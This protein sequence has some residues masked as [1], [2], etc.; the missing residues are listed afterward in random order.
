MR[1]FR[2]K[3][4]KH[5]QAWWIWVDNNEVHVKHGIVGGKL[6]HTYD[7]M[8]GIKEGTRAYVSPKANALAEMDR[9]IKKKVDAGYYEVDD[10][11][12]AIGSTANGFDFTELP[13][14][15]C[16][17]KPR[18]QP[19]EG[20]REHD[21][22]L[23]VLDRGD[24][25][26]TVKRDGFMHPILVTPE[27][28]VRIYTRR[29]DE[30]TSKYPHLA[31]DIIAAKVP[32]RSVLLC[33][34]FIRPTKTN[35]EDRLKMQAVSNSLPK[36]A[37]KLQELPENRVRA[38]ILLVPFWNGK[39]NADLRFF[40]LLQLAY[41]INTKKAKHFE[42]IDILPETLEDARR[43]V[44]DN[45]WEGL[46]IYDGEAEP[47]AK[48]FNF[49]GKPERPDCWKDKPEFEDDFIVRFDPS[50]DIGSWG[51]GKHKDT[52]GSVALEQYDAEGEITYICDVGSGFT[53]V[54]RAEALKRAKKGHGWCGV[55]EIKYAS[56][57]YRSR[58]DVSNALV[59]PV[60][61][62][63]RDDKKVSE[64]VNERL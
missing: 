57:R 4:K 32:R 29:M 23:K 33:E 62:R 13:K 63:W 12:N 59:E 22:L 26:I 45:E 47:G 39:S 30:C 55:A 20:T 28:D 53:E 24:E 19:D 54:E 58:G 34:F 44:K 18:P 48:T 9:L 56:R 46:V 8:V 2:I 49:R 43:M 16:F 42:P 51:R 25:V 10:N 7:V 6:Q 35:R 41:D 11:G 64:V 21:K 14:S 38:S 37:L 61:V 3:G 36:R 27:G 52:V 40:D 15:M 17:M 50:D 31:A 60:F 1:R 5:D